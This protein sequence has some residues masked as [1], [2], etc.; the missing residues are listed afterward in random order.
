MFLFGLK[1]EEIGFEL[2]P[3]QSRRSCD[4]NSAWHARDHVIDARDRLP[5]VYARFM[6]STSNTIRL[7]AAMAAAFGIFA[8]GF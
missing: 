8:R 3:R 4:S 7:K 6:R 1:L 2:L 5:A